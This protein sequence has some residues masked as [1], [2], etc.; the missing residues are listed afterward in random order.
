MCTALRA[1]TG[2][3]A[4]RF[5]AN[6]D[7]RSIMRL[8]GSSSEPFRRWSY[9]SAAGHKQKQSPWTR[10]HSPSELA[11]TSRARPHAPRQGSA[12]LDRQAT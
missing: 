11:G 4:L 1:P 6:S 7:L 9:G 10:S 12:A 2:R 3:E 5:A 8:V